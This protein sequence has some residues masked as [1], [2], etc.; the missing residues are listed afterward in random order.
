MK[1]I[2]VSLIVLVIALII[3]VILNE[4]FVWLDIEGLVGF[5]IE[6]MVLT[7]LN[8]VNSCWKFFTGSAKDESTVDIR[9]YY[10]GYS[11]EYYVSDEVG[12][13]IAK[14]LVGDYL[15][16]KNE[17]I[18]YKDHNEYLRYE[19]ELIDLIEVL[20]ENKTIYE[21]EKN[22]YKEVEQIENITENEI[23]DVK[24]IIKFYLNK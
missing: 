12:N 15:S 17:I 18:I 7:A 5:D 20:R 16:L 1:Y 24:N 13:E 14:G 4:K 19:K 22:Y 6:D 10:E 8:N 11:N 9:G 2:C 23:N 21:K 3:G